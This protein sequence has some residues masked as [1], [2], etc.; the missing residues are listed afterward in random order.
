[1]FDV[2]WVRHRRVLD[3]F[4]SWRGKQALGEVLALCRLAPLCL[5]WSIGERKLNKPIKITK[6][7]W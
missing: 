1:M 2:D 6:L 4:V 3:F 5:M 7:W